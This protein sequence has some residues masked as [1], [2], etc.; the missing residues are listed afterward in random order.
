MQNT[1]EIKLAAVVSISLSRTSGKKKTLTR[2]KK[3]K[4]EI[5]R[6]YIIRKG[7]IQENKTIL[8]ILH[9]TYI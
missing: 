6:P 2:I 3:K 9:L 1:N 5:L 8:V 4:K 7:T